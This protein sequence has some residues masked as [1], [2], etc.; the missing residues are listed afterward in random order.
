[1]IFERLRRLCEPRFAI[2]IFAVLGF[3]VYSGALTAGF[4]WD[5]PSH[6]LKNYNIHSFENFFRNFFDLGFYYYH[7][8]SDFLM[9]CL[10]VLFGPVPW[11]Y[12]LF[13]V[14]VHIATVVSIYFLFRR[15]IGNEISFALSLL[16]LVHPINV[17]AVTSIQSH[18]ETLSALFGV[19]ALL[20][21]SK[22]G[23]HWR[24]A[25]AVFL[26]ACALFTKESAIVF[27]FAAPIM[28]YF[29]WGRV[30]RLL[31]WGEVL[32]VFTRLL[33]H[34]STPYYPDHE[35]PDFAMIVAPLHERMLSVPKMIL[36]YVD[37]LVYPDVMAIWQNW[38][39]REATAQDFWGPLL[40]CL[41][42]GT[43]F[44]ALCLFV[45]R[46]KSHVSAPLATSAVLFTLSLGIHMQLVPLDM[47]VA[48][49]WF[50]TPF[51]ALI[52]TLGCIVWH[53]LG[54]AQL[55]RRVWGVVTLL[56]VLAITGFSLRTIH[57]NMDWQ[58]SLTLFRHDLAYSHTHARMFV[59]YGVSL[60]ES[61]PITPQLAEV[62]LRAQRLSP[63]AY[64]PY[65]NLGY[66]YLKT[67]RIED[68]EAQYKEAFKRGMS[69]E[70]FVGLGYVYLRVGPK[71]RAV[72][73]L[74]YATKT[75]RDHPVLWDLL[76]IAN[77]QYDRPEYGRSAAFIARKIQPWSHAEKA[78]TTA[79]FKRYL[80]L[81]SGDIHM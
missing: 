67:D 38:V 77:Y 79:K 35:F 69:A 33:Q 36:Y 66:T 31:F 56:L 61:Q 34:P 54:R 73:F 45:Y 55:P 32:T 58:D 8:V 16:F 76:A 39:V 13:Q 74:E 28:A 42:L 10:Y 24:I 80:H 15:F 44:V 53:F 20:L 25:A 72:R 27:F 19:W 62:F 22:Q 41:G 21:L 4:L 3:V 18:P 71:S 51:I 40:M 46:A 48:D 47:T 6:L 60:M 12:H 37:M 68:A 1:M 14:L 29:S 59:N 11:P 70:M 43:I 17:E 50:Y 57:R 23:T 65:V 9:T 5:D 7:P 81:T 64:A 2:P 26:L 78:A 52:G 49:R 30:P 75:Y 63:E